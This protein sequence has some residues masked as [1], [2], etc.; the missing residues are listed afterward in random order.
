MRS[1]QG[2][3]TP[4]ACASLG[5]LPPLLQFNTFNFVLQGDCGEIAPDLIECADPRFVNHNF[6]ALLE[7]RRALS[8]IYRTNRL[9]HAYFQPLLVSPAVV[10]SMH[11]LNALSGLSYLEMDRKKKGKQPLSQNG[12]FN[13]FD[14]QTNIR[15]QAKRQKVRHGSGQRVRDLVLIIAGLPGGLLEYNSSVRFPP[16]YIED[17]L[18]YDLEALGVEKLT[19]LVPAKCMLK[20]F[21]VAVSLSLHLNCPS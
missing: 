5:S 3:G 14:G 2:S 1:R 13:E 21:L 4:S 19:V 15:T 20:P 11:Q 9:T 17:F 12:D 18:R 8:R 10:T 7:R 16:W 6:C